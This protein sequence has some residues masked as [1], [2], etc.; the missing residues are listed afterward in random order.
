MS[1]FSENMD[2]YLYNGK[3]IIKF[4]IEAKPLKSDGYPELHSTT[5]YNKQDFSDIELITGDKKFCAHKAILA[6]HS[7]VFTTMFKTDMRENIKNVVTINDISAEVIDC[8]LTWIY[9]NE[10]EFH[11]DTIYELS[12][13]SEKCQ[14]FGLKKLCEKY[15]YELLTVKNWVEIISIADKCNVENLKKMLIAFI[16]NRK[17]ILTPE[18][19]NKLKNLNKMLILEVLECFV[20]PIT[21]IK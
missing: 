6:N 17:E 14:I 20:T 8:L 4:F 11:H 7:L 1:T 9:T 10:V 19:Y 12:Y 16:N 13:A 15:L 5:L 3:L 21:E 2:Y 18:T